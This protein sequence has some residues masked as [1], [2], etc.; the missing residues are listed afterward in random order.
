MT[1]GESAQGCSATAAVPALLAMAMVV[2]MR[3]RRAAAAAAA[4]CAVLFAVD[5]VIA[6]TRVAQAWTVTDVRTAAPQPGQRVL[7]TEVTFTRGNEVTVVKMQGG[8]WG[9]LEQIVDGVSVPVG[10]ETADHA[11]FF[12]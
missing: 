12:H 1:A 2:L 9:D 3:R 11:G 7:E 8:R 4:L 10:G 5:P 6:A